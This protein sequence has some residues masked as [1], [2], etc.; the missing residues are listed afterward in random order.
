[1]SKILPSLIARFDNVV[2]VIEDSKDL[3]ALSKYEFQS[4]LE[5]HEKMMY[6]RSNDKA[7]AKIEHGS[8]RRTRTQKE[9]G[10]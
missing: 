5:A 3:M 4:S 10:S 7:K 6:K 9:N 1:M 2:V 8:M